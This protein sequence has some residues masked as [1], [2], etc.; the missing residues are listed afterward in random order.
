MFRSTSLHVY[1]LVILVCYH[2]SNAARCTSRTTCKYVDEQ[3]AKLKGNLGYVG[4]FVDDRNR[5]FDTKK[6]NSNNMTLKR[7]RE[8]C[9]GFIYAGLQATRECFCGN[10]LNVNRYPPKQESECNRACPGESTRKC[11][12]HWR[13]SIYT[14][15]V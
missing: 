4:C 1:L 13:M 8:Q 10:Q 6:P 15:N 5:L 14:V 7:C 3:I 11:G 9:R 2:S 12:G